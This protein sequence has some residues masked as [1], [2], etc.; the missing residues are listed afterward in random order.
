MNIQADSSSVISSLPT[1]EF[2]R[3]FPFY[4][5]WDENGVILETGPSLPKF[6]PQAGIGARLQDVFASK[7]PEGEFSHA[8]AAAH[9]DRLFLLEE[10]H[11]QRMLRGQ[12]ILMD[13]PVR[14][15]ML[16]SPWLTDPE[17]VDDY[18][19]TMSDFAIHDQTLDL[20]Q[21]LQTQ[22]MATD[23]F[24]KLNK[25]LTEQR[26]QLRAQEA[27]SRKLALVAA[28]T[29][30]AVIV[31]DSQGRIEW[32]NEGF[33]RITGWQPEEV[34]GKKPGSFLQG[35]E[36]DPVTIAYMA[37]CLA[38][39]KSFRT[40]IQNY[41]R[42]GR[43]YWVALEVQPMHDENGKVVNF[44]AIESDITQRRLDE[45]RRAMQFS[46][47]R[48]LAEADTMRQ[49]AGKVIQMICTKLGWTAG[50]MWMV[51]P[52]FTE[53]RLAEIWHDPSRDIAAFAAESRSLTFES[54]KGLPGLVW[55]TGRAQWY[56]DFASQPELFARAHAAAASGLHG[57][58]A[59]PIIAGGD[60]IGAIEL[61]SHEILDPDEA[62]LQA[63]SGI[64]NQMGQYIV[65]RAAEHQLLQAKDAAETAS[66]A[67]SDFLATMSHEIRT[68]MN[69]IIGMSSL[70]LDTDLTPKQCEM[71][72]AVRQ[73]GESL[74]T[75]IEDILDF[76]KIEARKLELV[77]EAF[78]MDEVVRGVVDLL[79]HKAAAREI[80]LITHL[81]P[82]LPPSLLGDPGRLRQILMNLVG[83]GIKFTDDGS[84]RVEVKRL[85][86]SIEGPAN[87]EISV[88]DTGIGMTPEQQAQLFQAFTQ[89]D[90]SSTR[91]FGGTGLGLAICK[92]LVELM[93]G[94]IGVDSERF[95][96]SRFW[97][98]LPLKIAQGEPAP[99]VEE[100][101]PASIPEAPA[102]AVKPR[103]LV[104]EDNEVNARMAM[105]M[106][107]KH[108]YAAEVARDGEEA[109]DRFASG[110]YDAVL[111]DCHMPRMD[112]YEATR[113]IREIEASPMWKR[114][115]CRIIAMTAN[116]MAGE[117]ER[118]IAVGMDDYVSKPLRAKAL[119]EALS[120]ARVLDDTKEEADAPT[121]STDDESAAKGAVDQL[122]E[123]LSR[124]DTI[125]LIQN[126]LKDTPERILELE[127]LAGSEDQTSLR[128]VA[129][130]LKGSSSLFGLTYLHS[131]CRDLENLAEQNIRANQT[132]LVV[133]IKQA[134]EAT[135]PELARIGQ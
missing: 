69:G 62:L 92:R 79:R 124:E 108:G 130:A 60:T 121:W 10:L 36:T 35:P 44:M 97:F 82:D 45:Q 61:F 127:K 102:D 74:M 86:S 71:V 66:R 68:P 6:C 78:R 107:E 23:D 101:T 2:L 117:R 24:Q 32:V 11:T 129:H 5:V 128:R 81:D 70:L 88:T 98:H 75:I 135:A 4:F 48:I 17:Q 26:A 19:L 125:E 131:L 53:I 93:G 99:V 119:T 65:R 38:E 90:S 73:S 77:E 115:R 133:Q 55:E 52:G 37:K 109:V 1:R 113:T 12:I 9:T 22:R 91:R 41:H 49:A 123:E 83:N 110:V 40:E 63:L 18:G 3:A 30:N 132:A 7:R 89:V 25:R 8:M 29:D 27:Q 67:K 51:D 15:M 96:G 120:R 58:L 50:G 56:R 34:I 105:M 39:Q 106:L 54:G 42:N 126:W 72:E 59:F 28:R 57:A 95:A 80:D 43:K 112:G 122:I 13:E 104:V 14:G 46:A 21:V 64:G 114:P 16:G 134:F 84:I 87:L 100:T 116:V 31:S 33:T 111:M 76:S 47:S 94:C 103:L 85:P 20:L 118:C